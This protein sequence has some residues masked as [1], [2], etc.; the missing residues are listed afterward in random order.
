VNGIEI[1][2]RPAE[3]TSEEAAGLIG[4]LNAELKA[5]YP[6]EGA[7]HF[8]LDPD[9]VMEGRGAFLIAYAED[10]PVG[11]GAVRKLDD[12]TTELKRMYIVPE[13]RGAGLGRKMLSALE[14]E[15]RRLG[16]RRIVLETGERQVSAM[17]LY[18]RAGFIRIPAFG[19]YVDSPLSVCLAKE[20]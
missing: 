14:A 16:V 1:E 13:S 11:C 4:Q 12:T 19:E 8:R 17:A 6:E 10:R 9:E 15:S 20:L 2:I 18:Q 3:I 7:T 5:Q